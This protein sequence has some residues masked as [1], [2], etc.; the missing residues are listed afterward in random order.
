MNHA[1]S[2]ALATRPQRIADECTSANYRE[3]PDPDAGLSDRCV[4]APWRDSI[5]GVS[6]RGLWLFLAVALPMLAALLASLSSVD[7]AYHLRAGDE[8]LAAGA[9]PSVDTWTFT[10]TGLPWFDQQW[11]SEVALTV[12]YRLGG[13][14]GLAVL[15]AILVGVVFASLL[16]IG[17]R[18]GLSPRTATLLTLVAFGIAAPA[19]A[20]RAQL[21]G[22]AFFAVSLVLV[23]E[24]RRH[25]AWL[26]SIPVLVVP[27]ANIHG[28]FFLAPLVLGLAWL[29]DLTDRSPLRHRALMV[30]VVSAVTACLT[31]FGPTVWAYAVGLST[32]PEVT[33]RITEW[34]PTSIRDA[35][36]AVFFASVAALGVIIAR[37]GRPV[38]WPTLVWL[39]VFVAIGL[40]AQRGLAWWPLA[41]V[42]VVAVLLPQSI[43]TAP[44]LPKGRL[45]HRLNGAVTAVI[46]LA[47]LALLPAWRPVDP[48]TGVPGG[49]LTDAP[50]GVTAALRKATEPGDNVF[51]PQ[52][53][54]SWFEFAVPEA[55]Y[56]LDSRIEFFPP[57]VWDAY[58][59]VVV[60]ADGWQERLKDWQVAVIVL[61]AEDVAFGDRLLAAGWTET[62][63]DD[64]GSVFVRATVASLAT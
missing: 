19:L 27:W 50:P 17:V 14:T 52:P 48:A 15:R 47:G 36:G 25:P 37:R 61:Q 38:P 49:V 9:I 8:I 53:W 46:V 6:L 33:R 21:F 63:R 11:L 5:A 1:A 42:P 29:E 35:T 51:N 62:Y 2:A 40:Y 23:S 44:D 57:A 20:L 18:R 59:V 7:L 4:P 10:A 34:Q 64:D 30:G 32:N 16:A 43:A 45:I 24:R 13:W 12:V 56:A 41:A 55:R 3:P 31:P 39:G 58:E 28:S 26:W 54:G 60:G 22:M